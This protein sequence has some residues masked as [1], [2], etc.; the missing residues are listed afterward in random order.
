[1]SIKVKDNPDLVRDPKTKAV[2]N[3]NKTGYNSYIEQRERM[4]K[5]MNEIKS[6]KEDVAQLKALV[7]QLLEK[8]RQ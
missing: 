7:S 8:G 3:V 2:I 1:M 6:L 4:M 5:S